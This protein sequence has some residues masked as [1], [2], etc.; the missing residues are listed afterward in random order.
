[1][2][3]PIQFAGFFIAIQLIDRVEIL[4]LNARFGIELLLFNTLKNLCNGRG[5]A[6]VAVGN[7]GKNFLAVSTKKHV[8]DTPG[9]NSH[10]FGD[11]SKLFAFFNS[12][13]NVLCEL[14]DVPNT[15]SV[16]L[17]KAVFEA[18]DFGGF[19]SAVF[20]LAQNVAA[21][22][23]AYVDCKTICHFTYLSSVNIFGEY[24]HCYHITITC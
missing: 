15:G 17:L 18:V 24:I 9:V 16:L 11:F 4:L 20:K 14:L 12:F 22:G 5:G 7:A 6:W 2:R 13:D 10:G 23:S 1:M 19:E 3:R 8:V 21:A